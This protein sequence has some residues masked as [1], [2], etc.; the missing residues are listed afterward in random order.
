[1]K[2]SSEEL[3]EYLA[4][5][6]DDGLFEFCRSIDLGFPVR[7]IS[8]TNSHQ[9]N[10]S[11]DDWINEWDHDISRERDKII[12]LILQKKHTDLA[13]FERI[14]R[15]ASVRADEGRALALSDQANKVARQARLVALLALI[16]SIV[17]PVVVRLLD[18]TIVEIESGQEV[19][20][21]STR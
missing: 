21:S 2:T 20:A 13:H 8:G 9:Y 3:N 6:T 18:A 16:A 7:M 14:L 17:L 4:A 1:M 5:L 10:V 19:P 15:A 12:E 11:I